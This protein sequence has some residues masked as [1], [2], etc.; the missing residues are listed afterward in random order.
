MQLL[1]LSGSL[2]AGSINSAALRAAA[3]LAGPG[4]EVLVWARLGELPLFNPDREADSPASVL[5]FQRAVAAA[6]GL[7]IASPEHAH[8]V[9]GTIKNALDWL[10]GF[11]PFAG[12]RVAVLNTSPRSWFAD[13]A[14]RETLRTMAAIIVEPASI[15][16]PLLGS[17][18]DEDGMIADAAVA[19]ALRAALAALQDAIAAS[20]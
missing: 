16:I 19:G 1:A 10:V 14:L 4:I 20:D 11:A 7:L 17:R 12:K 5:A 6:N 18:L 13:A 2:R 3:R 15:A 8:S 9:S